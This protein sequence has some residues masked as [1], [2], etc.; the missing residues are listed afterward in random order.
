VAAI[1]REQ[2]KPVVVIAGS[3]EPDYDA[4]AYTAT[5]SLAEIAGSAASAMRGGAA[6]LREAGARAARLIS[7]ML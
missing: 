7:S 6:I 1:A 3:V 4:D 5:I 2:G